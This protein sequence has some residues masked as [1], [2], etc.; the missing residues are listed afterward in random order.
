MRLF[1]A[2]RPNEQLE[3]K[4][5]ELQ[6]HLRQEAAEKNA[7]LSYPKEFH[8][9]L[10]FLGETNKPEK[11]IAALKKVRFKPFEFCIKGIGFFPD[12]KR[13]RVVWA[14]I[15]PGQPFYELQQQIDKVLAAEGFEK[16]KSFHPHITLGRVK[17]AGK[18]AFSGLREKFAEKE[19]EKREE[20]KKSAQEENAES[21]CMT[22]AQFDLIRS[23]L[24][25]EGPLYTIVEYFKLE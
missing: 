18:G 10:K 12:E 6:T 24:K 13:P 2:I 1:I 4:V 19:E 23:E 21:I 14:G 5:K 7:K 25:P 11:I 22:A 15:G 20:T 8:L 16:D 9:T 17:F 3:T